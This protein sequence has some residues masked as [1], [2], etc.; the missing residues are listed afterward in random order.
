MDIK[1]FVIVG[2]KRSGTT[3]LRRSLD[4]H[5]DIVCHGEIF[6]PGA[7]TGFSWPASA[8]KMPSA[9]A[10]DADPVAY[11]DQLLSHHTQGWVGFKLLWGQSPDIQKE[12]VR[13]GYP[14]LVINR[15][16]MLAKFSS[17][18]ILSTMREAGE[19]F[20]RPANTGPSAVK[21]L[22]QER[23]FERYAALEQEMEAA[24]RAI[25]AGGASPLLEVTYEGLSWGDDI[26]RS[27]DFLGAPRRTLDPTIEKQNSSDIVSRFENPDDVRAYLERRGLQRWMR[28]GPASGGAG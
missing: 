15:E 13:R 16:N 23:R 28:E 12:M 27:L 26:G 25:C 20:L 9:E 2:A 8:A 3:F 17:W 6:A 11:L 24:F 7:P 21:A 22:F 10:R 5:P 18:R 1:P 14:L 4:D 19:P